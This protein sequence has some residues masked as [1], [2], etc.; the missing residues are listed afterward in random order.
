MNT[1]K[2]PNRFLAVLLSI[3]MLFTMLPVTAFAAGEGDVISSDTTWEDRII[4][5]NVRIE[6]NATITING[7][8]TISGS[9]TISGGGTIKRG[10][11]AGYFSINNGS[12]LTLDGVT[13][14]GENIKSSS[15]MFE[16][17]GGMLALKNNTVQNCIKSSTR[18]GA[19]NMEGG[20]LTIENTNITNCSANGYGGAIYL[21]DNA[22]ATIKSGTFSGNMTTTSS[23]GGGFIYNRS[24]LII[25]G[26]TFENN[27]STGRGGAIYNAGTSG[28]AAYIRGGVFQG[29]TSSYSGHEGSGAVYYSSQNTANTILEISGSAQ[30]GNGAA[31]DGTDGI[32]LD[33]GS[34]GTA[35]RKTQI[36]S[37]L[38][39]PL[40]IYLECSEKRVIAEG[41]SG[42]QLTAADMTKIQFHDV[43]SSGRE[44]YAWLNSMGNEVYLSATKP[45]YVIYDAN[46]A[47]GS[48]TDNTVYTAEQQVTVQSAEGLT[49][50]G[51]TFKGWNTD[52]DGK[53]ITYQPGQTFAITE[54]T[55]LY[56]Q[57]E[58][59]SYNVWV[60]GVQVTSANA[61]D[62]LGNADGEG[63]TVSYDT[64]TKT[65][66][67]NNANIT[68][69]G[70]A[71]AAIVSYDALHI[72]LAEG[73]ENKIT[74]NGSAV[75]TGVLVSE[76][77]KTYKDITVSGKGSLNIGITTSNA[78]AFGIMG[79]AVTIGGG[80]EVGVVINGTSTE[81]AYI[82]ITGYSSVAIE[83]GSTVTATVG[84]KEG[85]NMA[86]MGTGAVTIENADVTASGYAGI[87]SMGGVAINGDSTVT[88]TGSAYAIA[89]SESGNIAL[90][91]SLIAQG[92][93]DAATGELLAVDVGVATAAGTPN[94][95]KTFVLSSNTSTVAQYVEIVPASSL[96]SHAV[97]GGTNCGH[98]GHTA[99][100]YTALD[101]DISGKTLS[102]GNY[103]LTEDITDVSTSIQITGTVNLCLNGHTISGD[104]ENGI[105]RIGKNGVLNV[106]DCAGNGKVGETGT[107]GHNPVF[108]H[109]GG[110]LNL[111][112]GA[113]ESRITAVVIDE[114]PDNKAEKTGGTVNVYGGTVS[115]TGS[116]SQAIKVNA[117]M[118]NAAVHIS[119]G[120]VRSEKYGINAASGTVKV[121]DGTVEGKTNGIY[122]DNAA[123]V[124]VSGGTVNGKN[125]AAVQLASA[126]SR[127]SLSGTPAITGKGADVSLISGS[128]LAEEA[129]ISAESYSGEERTI[130][131]S[132][133]VVG[134]YVVKNVADKTAAEKFT[135]TG[136]PDLKLAYDVDAKALKL[137]AK[138]FTVTLTQGAGY[139]LTEKE[140]SASPVA[141]GGSY[142]FTLSL[143]EKAY[144]TAGFAVKANGTVLTLA[145]DSV[146]TISN[147][148]QDQTV[149][150]EGVALDETAP[151]AEIRLGENRWSQFLNSITFGLFF[152]DTQTVTISA[153]DDG[154]GVEKTEYFISDTSCET[155]EALEEA[156]KEQWK[157]YSD[158]FSIIPNS[159]NVIYTKVT[160]KVGNVTY[161]NSAG[162][163]LYTDAAQDTKSISFT[164]TG[165]A[166]VTANV[167]LN[168][169][170]IGEIYCGEA[171]LIP[172]TD[173]TVSGETITFK[174]SW[175]N[176]LAA[177]DY[178]LTVSYNPMG[179]EYVSDNGNDKPATTSISLHVQ[180]AAGSVTNLSDISKVYD[181]SA[182]PNVTYEASSTGRVTVEYK[183]RN[184][185][186]SAY[187]TEKP[188]AVGRYTVRVTVAADENYTEASAAADFAID[189]LTT[190]DTPF[191]ISG[192][193]GENGW[194]TSDVTIAPP[195]GYTISDTL[196]GTYSG[197]LTVS[198]SKEAVTI[199]LR[200]ESG[201][202]TGA[203]SAGGIKIDKDDPTIAATGN[204]T[205]Y[206]QG[207]TVNIAASDS[208]SGV[209]RVEVK[210]DD[211]GFADITS[212]YKNGYAVTENGTYTFRVTDHAGRTAEKTLV[213][214]RIDSAKPVV[215]I[216]AAHGGEDYTSGAWTNRDITLTPE[217]TTKNLGTTTY[218][219]RVDNGEWQTYTAPIVVSAD[220]DADGSVY[221]F[222]AAS[223]SGVESDVASIT[224]KR[225]TVAPEGDVTIKENS[226]RRF[227]NAITFGLFFNE[228]VDVAITGTDG[229]SGVASVQY[230]RS[231]EILAEDEMLSLNWSHY[232]GAIHETAE[233]TEKFIYY[234]KVTDKAGNITRFA[235]DGVVFD[236]TN[237]VIDGIVN[238]SAY[239][240][241]QKVVVT[242]T[243]L[244]SVKLNGKPVKL[245]SGV[246]MLPGNTDAAYTITA[247]DKAGNSTTVTVTMKPIASLAENIQGL[248]EQN[249][250]SDDKETIDAVKTDM[251]AVDTKNA[252][253]GE[254]AAL[255]DILDT[256]DNLLKTID[257]VKQEISGVTNGVGGYDADSIKSSDKDAIEE[258]IE[259]IDVLLDGDN[260]T[261]TEKQNLETVKSAAEDLLDKI[262]GTADEIS[263]VTNGVGGYDVD[264]VK[265]SDKEAIEELVERIDA[266]LDGDNLTETEKQNLETVKSAAEDL[267]DKI[268]GTADEI[269]DVTNGVGGYDV[270][271][272]KSS[273]KE[274]I[275]EL[276]ERIDALLDSENLTEEEK[277]DLEDV[278]DA[279][280]DLLDKIAGTADEIS[281]VTNGVGGYDVGTVKSSDKEAVEE[282][283]KHIDTLLDGGNL[284]VEEKLDLEDV[285]DTAGSLLEK[286]DAVVK[287]HDRLAEEIGSYETETVT[288]D[289]KTDMETLLEDIGKLLETKNLTDEEITE[290]NGLETKLENLLDQLEGIAEQV[291]G[292]QEGLGKYEENTVKSTDKD[293]IEQLVKDAEALAGSG[294]VTAEEKAVL[295]SAAEEG[296]QL[297][298]KIAETAE[299]AKPESA[300]TVETVTPDNVAIGDKGALEEALEDL[301]NALENYG[302]NYTEAEKADIQESVDR[303]TDALEAIEH[304]ED[305]SS[306]IDALPDAENVKL[307]DETVIQEAQKV[308][309]ALT[310]HEKLLVSPELVQKLKD[311]QEALT[312]AKEDAA[313]GNVGTPQTGDSSKPGFWVY[314]MLLGG[315]G[316][317]GTAFYSRKKKRGNKA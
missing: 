222:K 187:T 280:E 179:E 12:V 131:I 226:V 74:L 246:L 48:V 273:D 89:T 314:L 95:Y 9:V 260:L 230:Y 155:T 104:A 102:S 198:A 156:A 97:C 3:C 33:V 252:A 291:N 268:A 267:L 34:G 6:N 93:A 38:Q 17:S 176:T 135:Y 249:V 152:K 245:E 174:A 5:K 304:A 165:T 285:R 297:L 150:V 218:Q 145:G 219:Y 122:A 206:L 126:G 311:V 63:A 270:D 202:M 166:D 231:A 45:C 46:G 227:L 105:F 288:A 300:Q 115:S 274:A 277:R 305:T 195:D 183:E 275:E 194:Y 62:V 180:K 24:K 49:Y 71:P 186:D 91:E 136:K 209:A 127:L 42:Y 164:K 66:T 80:A 279:A 110:M 84:D 114:D 225:D 11:S 107:S 61:S 298:D 214:D 54:T 181:G 140:G 21:R 47:T 208:T 65:L 264:T 286:I 20:T 233:D 119:G 81:S 262:A 13:V 109:S 217:N 129:Q 242:D 263:D 94:P 234:V 199:Y 90:D 201:Q 235:S 278:R 193:Q 171:K 116:S 157:A 213:Y 132:S 284:T 243:N 177:G 308:Y 113:I 112:S 210:K 207:D 130:Q 39:H 301:K 189:Y 19:I 2:Q 203:V 313:D 170:T 149:T 98:D 256:C 296:R 191:T 29:N 223:A 258:L 64:E 70:S 281:G 118:T 23:Y 137:A 153:A 10:N 215:T 68:A 43:G 41:V 255:Q 259:R 123:S 1:R 86:I 292:L 75:L 57:W 28:T 27:S 306:K 121:T 56:A 120:T 72:V 67:L 211:G 237:P 250:T 269:S 85:T 100:S 315:A 282:L 295:E 125:G 147:I 204:T 82:G 79:S 117:D 154:S 158:S 182:V 190:P 240:T 168:G 162:I 221:E 7:R 58:V 228:N 128:V 25:E 111:Y 317:A 200:N 216:A 32:Y 8:I 108:L 69:A 265:S 302:D 40:H 18:G 144:K 76:N 151:T 37:A 88:A 16:V 36:S 173:Y 60:G 310:E 172:E 77:N 148:T 175:L 159:K 106:C 92:G 133:P 241:T 248:M 87:M 26:G 103:Y 35:I 276:V 287:E 188:S 134:Q 303:I 289:D 261:E 184:A 53:G 78:V 146:Y 229:L 50:E 139:T 44:W 307:A 101:S 196:N 254:K 197:S 294:N 271:T 52:K 244:D 169:N 99:V 205:D 124:E 51:A 55:T 192:T 236:L 266:L 73:S 143:D 161:V 316:T 212:S 253:E 142:S 59:E 160:D 257:E 163:V 293:A 312:T 141:Y 138:T 238:G 22:V 30:F 96:H 299:A 178:T 167:T 290:L 14:D 4:S 224:V 309:D 31:G 247:T 15:S 251:N 239:Y 83:E 220:T 185:D 272:V 232:E 283:V